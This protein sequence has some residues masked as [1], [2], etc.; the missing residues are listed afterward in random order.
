MIDLT[1]WPFLAMQGV[2]EEGVP[3]RELSTQHLLLSTDLL[4]ADFAL[5]FF[6]GWKYKIQDLTR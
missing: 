3:F 5:Y 4:K 2:G 1:P 6:A